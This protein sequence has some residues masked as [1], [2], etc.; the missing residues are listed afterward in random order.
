MSPTRACLVAFALA[1]LLT[2]PATRLGAAPSIRLTAAQR[3]KVAAL[4]KLLPAKRRT[5]WIATTEGLLEHWARGEAKELAAMIAALERSFQTKTPSK[6][7]T[8]A[9][10]PASKAPST[11]P[12]P[13][14]KGKDATGVAILID[15]SGS[16]RE[17][18]RG[19]SEA[20]KKI[21]S[22]WAAAN[23]AL[24]RLKRFAVSAPTKPL[25]TTVLTFSADVQ[26]AIPLRK[27]D[28]SLPRLGRLTVRT[29]TAIGEG[30]L[31]AREKLL[32]GGLQR[33]HI[34]VITDGQN[35]R[36]VSPLTVLRAFNLLPRSR[37]PRVHL[38]AFDVSS[39]IFGPLKLFLP[40]VHQARDAKQLDKVLEGLFARAIL[41]E[42][43]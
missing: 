35:S 6:A 21:N 16:M 14:S 29:A 13:A 25:Y 12:S 31:A 20:E 5:A 1:A 38:V 8:P 41:A 28:A 42:A 7:S 26:T 3:A 19:S 24:D 22:A 9:S 2:L 37:F 10:T 32:A 43:R 30:L 33:Q 34:V 39:G 4:A 40:K 27:V 36:G 18:P 15:V 23:A 17:P 11:T